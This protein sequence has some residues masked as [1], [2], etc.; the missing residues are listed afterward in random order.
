MTA[1]ASSTPRVKVRPPGPVVL[2]RLT[3]TRAFA[4]LS[5]FVFHLYHANVLGGNPIPFTYSVMAYFFTLSG[6][7]LT[8]STA[9]GTP[10]RV[11]YWRRFARI[12]PN[13]LTML[14]IALL[15]PVTRYAPN[16]LAVVANVFLVQAWVPKGNVLF[17]LNALSWS[18]SVEVAFYAAL[19]FVVGWLRR[20]STRTRWSAAGA[21]FLADAVVVVIAAHIGGNVATGGYSQP[22]L[23]AGEFMLGCVAALEVER[24]WRVPARVR[25]PLA[26]LILVVAFLVP[27]PLPSLNVFL[28]PMWLLLLIGWVQADLDGRGGFLTWKPV[29]YAGQL[30]FAF[31]LTHDLVILNFQH[32]MHI[33]ALPLCGLMF[34]GALGSAMLLHHGVEQPAQ[35]ALSRRGPRRAADSDR[36]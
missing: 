1:P 6:F 29:L 20:Q 16:A 12:W 9:P 17:G 26:T 27:H 22:L 25:W 5:V 33:S 7:V 2:P 8:W 28:A 19:P 18:L 15:V 21:L 23:R 11:Y 36:L 32:W 3:A 4:A 31:Y 34:L 10:L 24:G 13:H 35:R 30:S 14:A